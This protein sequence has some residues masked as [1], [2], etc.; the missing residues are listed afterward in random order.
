MKPMLPT[1]SFEVPKGKEWYYEVKYD[2]FRAIL[3]INDGISLVSRNGH[4]LIHQFPELADFLAAH[5]DLIEPFT[6]LELDGELVILE[7]EFKANFSAIQTRGRMRA[8]NRIKEMAMQTPC[9][10]LVFDLLMIKGQSLKKMPY[11]ERK[12]K[13]AELFETVL[14]PLTPTINSP[15]LIQLVP[16]FTSIHDVWE[17]VV[18]FDG[19]GIISK[20]ANNKW[21]EGKRT[22]LWIK[23]KNWKFVTCFIT[24]YEKSNGYFHVAVQHEKEII[25]IGQFLFGLKPE[26]KD[27]LYQTIMKNTKKEDRKLIFVEPSICV[28]LKYLEMYDEQ[29]R[30]PHFHRFLFDTLPNDCTYE[31]F[32]FQQLNIPP[33]I[34]ITHPEKPLWEE[35]A[36]QKKDYIHYLRGISP[37]IL[38]FLMNRTLT[39]IRYPHGMLSHEA[40]YQKNCPDYAP[41]FVQTYNLEGINYIVCNDVKTLIWLGNQLAFEFH[42]PF[43]TIQSIGPS[44]IVFDLDPPSKNEFSLAI[45][46]ALKIKEVLDHFHLKSFVKTSGNKGLQIY[47]PLPENKYSYDET[48]KI[49]AFIAEYL[50]TNDPNS[51]TI[52]RLKKNRGNRLYVDYIQHG[53]GKTIVAPYSPRGNR[54]ATVSTPL[55]WNEVKEGLSMEEFQIPTLLH[56]LREKG[57]PFRN[58]FPSKKTQCLTPILQFISNGMNRN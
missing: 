52:E 1:L 9:R 14:F 13:L 16:A 10:L 15:S 12:Q 22:P 58:Y 25:P 38:P 7:N 11:E 21:E 34:E 30:E 24:A 32:A 57:C 17:Q 27:A 41:D 46:A 47:I 49:T 48:R 44:E 43:Q 36:I 42:I 37:Y 55:F 26:E 33:G 2:G 31:K 3:S 39:V 19:E 23:L 53:E 45:R 29:M 6:P 54:Q 56:R 50:V 28:E 51:F 5:K 20:H 4:S 35:P 8:L 18:L 40:F